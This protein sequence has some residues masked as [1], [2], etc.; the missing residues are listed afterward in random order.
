VGGGVGKLHTYHDS[1]HVEPQG[2][3]SHKGKKERKADLRRL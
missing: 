1:I 3:C 2:R